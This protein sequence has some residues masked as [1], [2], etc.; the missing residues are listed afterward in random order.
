MI[1]YRFRAFGGYAASEADSQIE[2][3]N[4]PDGMQWTL[5]GSVEAEN[6]EQ[7]SEKIQE[8]ITEYGFGWEWDGI[9]IDDILPK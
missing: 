8:Q 5:R 4:A 6:E 3:V 2:G 7:A 1:T 9:D